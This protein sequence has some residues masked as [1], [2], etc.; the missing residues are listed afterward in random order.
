MRSLRSAMTHNIPQP[1][2][3]VIATYCKTSKANIITIVEAAVSP[4]VNGNPVRANL[5]ADMITRIIDSDIDPNVI[6]NIVNAIKP[7]V[8]S[9][10][11]VGQN[12]NANPV[13]MTQAQAM[14]PTPTGARQ[15]P[16][17]PRKGGGPRL[18]YWFKVV[19][20]VDMK[21]V[22]GYGLKGKFINFDDVD[23]QQ[24]GRIIVVQVKDFKT[25]AMRLH[26]LKVD[27]NQSCGIVLPH[28][29]TLGITGA[30]L[31]VT[32]SNYKDLFDILTKNHG[33]PA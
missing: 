14:T 19:T 1:V 5:Y 20:S 13:P 22:N 18:P 2:V 26:V 21:T 8:G 3:D 17:A 28:G 11:V 27:A 30:D 7:H 10:I 23:K 16:H 24:Q 6:M 15:S 9:G 4:L 29:N 33:I 32:L 31:L 12:P 25:K